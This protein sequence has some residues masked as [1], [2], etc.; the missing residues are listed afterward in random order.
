MVSAILPCK[1]SA[2]SVHEG[3]CN[4]KFC[5]MSVEENANGGGKTKYECE[6]R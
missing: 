2:S 1:I 4:C 6:K 5:A 3:Q